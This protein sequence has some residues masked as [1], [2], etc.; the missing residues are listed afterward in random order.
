MEPL[1]QGFEPLFDS[2][3]KVLVLGSFPSVKSRKVDFY[4]GNPR[5]RFWQMMQTIFGGEIDT[6]Q[7]KT[8]LCLR[9]NDALWDIVQ[10][11]NVKGSADVDIKNPQF[12]DLDKVL[13]NSNVCKI[14]CNGATAYK[15]ATIAYKGNLPVVQLPSTSPANPRFDIEKWKSELCLFATCNQ[16]QNDN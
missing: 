3:S 4:Y 15:F 9:N 6:V 11:C 1:I 14:L 16:P 13:K 5:N 7:H 12:V 2:N 8:E 10:C